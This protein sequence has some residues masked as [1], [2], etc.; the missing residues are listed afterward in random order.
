MTAPCL[1]GVNKEAAGKMDRLLQLTSFLR[2][3]VWIAYFYQAVP[4]W[5][6][7]NTR[8]GQMLSNKSRAK[9]AVLLPPSPCSM[10]TCP[11]RQCFWQ[12][13]VPT[14]ELP[15]WWLNMHV[16]YLARKLLFHVYLPLNNTKC[17]HT[18]SHLNHSVNYSSFNIIHSLS[19]NTV[20]LPM[21]MLMWGNY[22]MNSRSP[23]KLK[24]MNLA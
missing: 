4:I 6:A 10:L 17:E 19:A 16:S 7:P 20:I 13:F 1:I 24:L 14:E 22:N 2:R 11:Q 8:H 9:L 15:M 5:M 3:S 12:R 18:H 21:T 23:H